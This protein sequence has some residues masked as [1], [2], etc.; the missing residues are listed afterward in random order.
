MSKT[1]KKL[2]L[3]I[4][5]ILKGLK[6]ETPKIKVSRYNIIEQQE[7]IEKS[8]RNIMVALGLDL[9]NDSLKDTP[10]RI[11]KMYVNEIFEGLNYENF[12]KCTTVSNEF[13]CDEMVTVRGIDVSSTCEHHFQNIVGRCKIAYIPKDK[14]LGLSKLNRVVRFFSKRPQIQERLTLQIYHALAHVLGTEDIAVEI[15]AVHHRVAAR[16]IEDKNSET[17]TRKLGGCFKLEPETRA[18][19]LNS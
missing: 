14:V 19:F 1:D 10:V 18:E 7:I 6:I 16:G 9:R 5:E 8:H 3:E 12:P 11:A 17:S 15:V 2:G 4:S 13:Q